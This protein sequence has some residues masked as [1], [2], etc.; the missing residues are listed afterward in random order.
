[1]PHLPHLVPAL[2]TGPAPAA[3]CRL[4]GLLSLLSFPGF[5]AL[6]T[7][8]V[9]QAGHRFRGAVPLPKAVSSAE[10]PLS[11]ES[12]AGPRCQLTYPLPTS[13][14][15]PPG[16]CCPAHALVLEAGFP[17]GRSGVFA[18]FLHA[19][20]LGVLSAGMMSFLGL[21]GHRLGRDLAQ[22]R[23]YRMKAWVTPCSNHLPRDP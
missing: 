23:H 16:L 6:S 21:F 12:P 20:P 5:R 22:G 17:L 14:K 18:P 4:P 13:K 1:M 3:A 8:T 2:R 15:Q 7:G 11:A 9:P 10:R 19:Q